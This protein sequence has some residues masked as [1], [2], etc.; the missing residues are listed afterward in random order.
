MADKRDGSEGLFHE[1][2][3]SCPMCG[4]LLDGLPEEHICPE[5][6][7]RYDRNAHI[8]ALPRLPAAIYVGMSAALLVTGVALHWWFNAWLWRNLAPLILVASGLSG[9][10]MA[11]MGLR[12]RKSFSLV[13][14]DE[15]R[16]F[17]HRRKSFFL[18]SRDEI[19]AFDYRQEEKVIPMN[20]VKNAEWSFTEGS[21]IFTGFDGEELVTIR[22]EFFGS[23]RRA[24]S[25]ASLIQKYLP[26]G[27]KV[28]GSF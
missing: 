1:M 19:R 3:G 23:R 25:F 7:F 17:D 5:C 27:E 28:S 22:S 4:Y 18:V 10:I 11:V 26:T 20:Q 13:S 12:L 2:L 21:V 6:G 24:K 14:R 15:V 9:I 16:A 8:L